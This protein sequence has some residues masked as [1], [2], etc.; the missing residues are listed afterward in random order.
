MEHSNILGGSSANIR[1]N[2]PAS[3]KLSEDIPQPPTSSYAQ[4]GTALHM[5]ME[6]ITGEPVPK[7]EDWV[8]AVINGIEITTEIFVE[9]ILPAWEAT[10]EAFKRL[11]ISDYLLEARVKYTPIEDSFGTCDILAKGRDDLVVVMDYKFGRGVMV[12]PVE[13]RQLMY[14]AMAAMHDPAYKDFWTGEADQ[15]V[16]L[17]IIQPGA[18]HTL[19]TWE[20][21]AGDLIAFDINLRQSM[22]IA[23]EGGSEPQMGDWCRWCRAAPVCPAKLEA[24]GA[25]NRLKKEHLND[26]S[27]ALE[28]VD[29]LTPWIDQVKKM[30]KDQI[31]R[32]DDIHGWKLVVYQQRQK[33]ANQQK[34]QQ[35]VSNSRSGINKD[36]YLSTKFASPAEIKK[37]CKAKGIDF[38]KFAPYIETSD[39]GEQLVPVTDR[40]EALR[41]GGS[42]KSPDEYAAEHDEN[43]QK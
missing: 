25:I 31:K 21:T 43:E 12:S 3:L 14:Y 30:G 36:E 38:K 24:A 19:R 9:R 16:V 7:V 1:L 34:I 18:E 27:V 8:G 28:L 35:F 23:V 22:Y 41:F 6:Q 37:I 32:G 29:Q 11:D 33:W 17:G 20:C 13:N 15:P 26:L 2:C 40:R 42:K 10:E 39:F 5:I 4:E